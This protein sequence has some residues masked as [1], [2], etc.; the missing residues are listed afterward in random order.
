MLCKQDK[1][2]DRIRKRLLALISTICNANK[3]ARASAEN[4]DELSGSRFIER[5]VTDI[6]AAAAALPPSIHPYKSFR[7]H[8]RQ[9]ISR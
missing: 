4:M 2:S 8:Q 6:A 1:E 9:L 7:N 5:R 3:I